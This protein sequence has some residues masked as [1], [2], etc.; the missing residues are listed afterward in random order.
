MNQ[1][2][3]KRIKQLRTEKDLSREDLALKIGIS[4][5]QL[6]RIET[7]GANFSTETLIEL[8]KYFNVDSNYIL[9]GVITDY[10]IKNKIKDIINDWI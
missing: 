5:A 1:Q 6:Y 4:T 9:D 2:I 8:C 10:F 7:K 3:G